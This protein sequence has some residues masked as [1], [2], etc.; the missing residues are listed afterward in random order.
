MLQYYI[1]DYVSILIENYHASVV[2]NWYHLSCN[3]VF[4]SAESVGWGW[5]K[6]AIATK[7]YQVHTTDK[8]GFLFMP[9]INDQYTFVR[10]SKLVNKKAT[11][12]RKSLRFQ[13]WQLKCNIHSVRHAA[14]PHPEHKLRATIH[15][16][17]WNGYPVISMRRS[18][19][20][21]QVVCGRRLAPC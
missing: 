2:W 15:V 20:S 3:R 21:K 6:I 12:Q 16:Q 11:L 13:L 10:Y 1:F 7:W 19:Q 18:V 5:C 4:I 14:P 17:N 9:W 8:Y